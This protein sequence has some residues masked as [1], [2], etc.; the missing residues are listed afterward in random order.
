MGLSR[1]S[2]TIPAFQA[3]VTVTSLHTLTHSHQG[4]CG[5]HMDDKDLGGHKQF[6]V[7]KKFL[8]EESE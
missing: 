3:P 7:N 2:G 6:S 8:C 1:L 5:A 4:Q